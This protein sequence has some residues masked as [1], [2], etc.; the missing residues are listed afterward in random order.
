MRKLR[1]IINPAAYLFCGYKALT[2]RAAQ[3]SRALQAK[4]W[5]L[6][7]QR[8]QRWPYDV[9]SVVVIR[10]LFRHHVSH[11]TWIVSLIA[12]PQSQS[13]GVRSVGL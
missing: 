13:P 2:L 11:V 10:S 12:L 4:E 7:K 5:P 8:V 3:E 6:S 9:V 1:D